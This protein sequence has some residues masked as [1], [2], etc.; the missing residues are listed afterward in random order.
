MTAEIGIMNK[1]AVA[2]AADSAV[3][4]GEEKVYNS[5]NKLFMLSKYYPIGIMIYGNATLMG[6]PWESI[7]K[8]FRKKIG[9]DKFDTLEEYANQLIHFMDNNNALFT[10]VEQDRY[11]YATIY[12]Y[13]RAIRE[14]IKAEVNSIIAK[15]GKI[16]DVKNRE[17]ISKHI[18]EQYELWEKAEKLPYIIDSHSQ[19]VINKYRD[20]IKDAINTVFEKLP[21][22]DV[23]SQSLEKTC[24]NLFSKN[25]FRKIGISGVVIAG[26]G[27]KEIFPVT[28]HFAIEGVVLNRIKYKPFKVTKVGNDLN[29]SIMP[30]AQRETV[31][32]FI[33]GIDP[34]F[35]T[36]IN[37]YL[38]ALFN[39]YPDFI[40]KEIQ[41]IDQKEKNEVS[42]K[43]KK[44]SNGL[45]VEFKKEMNRYK[46][47]KHIN[48]IID[49]VAVLP[50]DELAAMAEALVNLTSFKRRISM[51]Q[52][53]VGGPIDVAVISKGDGFVWIKR[54]HY[55][56]PELNP[57]FFAN[58]FYSGEKKKEKDNGT[59]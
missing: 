53:T 46:A 47:E 11:F 5:V 36:A 35:F 14:D 21:I 55:F 39:Q 8:I 54:K 57:Q 49:A 52:E 4:V 17:I 56:K 33:Q 48:P 23:D 18:K 44:A 2:L 43:I 20:K 31:D 42:E 22:S 27:E 28:I 37:S 7:I 3:T 15:E 59:E 6:V 10:E 25:K 45:L 13:F 24:G 51:E 9:T 40:L 1:M 30:F 26:F 12:H 41:Q 32:T 34:N 58:Y 29:A 19:E 38:L 50:K 16:D